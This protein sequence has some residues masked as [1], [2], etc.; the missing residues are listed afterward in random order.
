MRLVQYAAIL[1]A[2]FCGLS[3]QHANADGLKNVS[4]TKYESRAP[5]KNYGFERIEPLQGW[6]GMNYPEGVYRVTYRSDDKTTDLHG[7]LDKRG[8]RE[9]WIV[10]PHYRYVQVLSEGALS[11]K[12]TGDSNYCILKLDEGQCRDTDFPY[13]TNLTYRKFQTLPDWVAPRAIY[14]KGEKSGTVDLQLFTP[15]DRPLAIVR[16]VM[17]G[18]MPDAPGPYEY[19]PKAYQIGE[20]LS[21]RTINAQGQ[22]RDTL[23]SLEE[24]GTVSLSDVPPHAVIEYG[25]LKSPKTN[26]ERSFTTKEVQDNG[27]HIM[28]MTNV[29]LGLVWP[30][31]EGENALRPMP[32]GL[33]GLKPIVF[34]YD[35]SE[36]FSKDF[37]DRQFAVH[38]CCSRPLGWAVAW[39]TPDGPLYSLLKTGNVPGYDAVLSSRASAKYIDIERLWEPGPIQYTNQDSARRDGE[40]LG[41]YALHS[42]SGISEVYRSNKRGLPDGV[43]MTLEA[44]M[45]S[46]TFPSWYD[47]QM[48]RVAS[49]EAARLAQ[50]KADRERRE[51]ER[52]ARSKALAEQRSHMEAA[53]EARL[54]AA[55]ASAP[56][57]QVAPQGPFVEDVY[58]AWAHARTGYCNTNTLQTDLYAQAN[59][60]EACRNQGGNPGFTR[61][62]QSGYDPYRSNAE[63]CY[64]ARAVTECEF[65]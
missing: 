10:Q 52:M 54:A 50:L 43:T 19:L 27:L 65:N 63:Q 7:I 32:D 56:I 55:A 17:H 23:V 61:I 38:L 45:A 15:D 48:R 12:R 53:A 33:L 42:K 29:E 28:T 21:L 6:W 44:S 60:K 51:A 22:V 26:G 1:L 58:G 46:L 47:S 34:E 9:K 5:A 59:A 11:L 16:G 2:S 64:Q 3:V 49:E 39:D 14:V 62:V 40:L 24:A 13:Q 18:L 57:A 31:Y 36:D 30:S 8:K 35:A 41:L 20:K 37:G 4:P 25:Y